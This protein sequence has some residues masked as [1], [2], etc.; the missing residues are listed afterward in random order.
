MNFLLWEQYFR[1]NQGHFDH[2]E[3]APAGRLTGKE[4]DRI[5]SSIRQFQRGEHSEGKHFLRFARSLG[6]ESFIKALEIFIR[7]EQDHAAVLG[8]FMEL[9]QIS[10]LE[11]DRLDNIFRWLRK[12][13]GLEGTVTVLLTAE[14]ISMVYYKAL[15]FATHS[16]L[17]RQICRQILVDEEMHLRFQ[18]FTLSLLYKKKSWAGTLFSKSVHTILMAG[19]CC[20]V[21]PYHRKVLRAGGFGFFSYFLETWKQF[22]NCKRMIDHPELSQPV[23][24]RADPVKQ[25]APQ[26][27]SNKKAK[28]NI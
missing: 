7:E 1:F 21:W 27:I 6:D 12:L 26:N 22:R 19:T 8:R 18:S 20:I 9:E 24:N 2:L 17:L 10:R 28:I 23:F 4:K 11:K 25:K 3:W 14:I 13:A 16:I 15:Q 5:S